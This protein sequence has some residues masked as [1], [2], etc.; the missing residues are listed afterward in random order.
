MAKKDATTFKAAIAAAAVQ[1]N[2][3]LEDDTTADEMANEFRNGSE[4]LRLLENLFV[5]TVAD[6]Q[7]VSNDIYIDA[8]YAG[9][10]PIS[11]TG[12]MKKLEP[13]TP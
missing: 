13:F 1:I 10:R 5:I 11:R 6:G 8:V 7:Y 4:P 12:R 9:K 3:A 2:L